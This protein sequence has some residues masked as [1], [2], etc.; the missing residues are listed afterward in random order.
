VGLIPQMGDQSGLSLDSHVVVLEATA[1][2][3]TGL[4]GDRRRGLGWVTVTRT[5]NGVDSQANLRNLAVSLDR[6]RRGIKE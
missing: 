5:D 2:T 4:G 1:R 3:V 6:L